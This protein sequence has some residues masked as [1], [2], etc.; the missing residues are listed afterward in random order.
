MSTECVNNSSSVY[1][2]LEEFSDH[3]E[4]VLELMLTHDE[5]RLF[6]WNFT[7]HVNEISDILTKILECTTLTREITDTLSALE[8]PLKD[9][10]EI[11]FEVFELR[12]IPQN[13]R[14]S[15][16]AICL[17]VVL[18]LSL[19]FQDVIELLGFAI[20]TD[21]RLGELLMSPYVSEM[22]ADI[23]QANNISQQPQ[24]CY[25]HLEALMEELRVILY[26]M[27]EEYEFGN[28]WTS[29]VS[30]N[31]GTS[32]EVIEANSLPYK[33]RKIQRNVDFSDIM[34]K[35]VICMSNLKDDDDV[36]RLRCF[37]LFHMTC[38]DK[39]LHVNS[40]CPVCR[41]DIGAANSDFQANSKVEG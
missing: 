6:L 41:L 38:A 31:H 3:L 17:A 26:N 7:D 18:I 39:W 5:S 1:W 15:V 23:V 14:Y 8:E 35:C 10:S 21:S 27:P 34:E 4:A 19:T 25:T 11:L 12:Y 20:E 29:D 28:P 22:F 36:R 40:K 13:A 30:D 2:H 33:Y 37:H 16:H 9:A 24:I 32:Q